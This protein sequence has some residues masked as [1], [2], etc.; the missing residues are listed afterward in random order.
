MDYS[1]PNSV[2]FISKDK[3]H[4]IASPVCSV[5][6]SIWDFYNYS[7][8]HQ[9]INFLIF[10]KILK[11]IF[12][13]LRANNQSGYPDYKLRQVFHRVFKLMRQEQ[14]PKRNL[15]WLHQA[16]RIITNWQMTWFV[17]SDLPRQP[18]PSFLCLVS[19]KSYSSLLQ[20]SRPQVFCATLRSSSH[21]FSIHFR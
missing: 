9:Q 13:K 11:V 7:D 19:M 18:L 1:I 17:S 20:M 12:S 10:M 3:Y 2:C 8:C 14:I 15:Q 16:V 5:L 21:F 4:K 6:W